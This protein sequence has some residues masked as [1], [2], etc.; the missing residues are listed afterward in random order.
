MVEEQVLKTEETQLESETKK[1]LPPAQY[2]LWTGK[3]EIIPIVVEDIIK[4]EFEIDEGIT[5]VKSGETSQIVISGFGLCLSKKSERMLVKKSKEILYEFPLFRISEVVIASKGISLSSDLI[6]ELCKRG[7]KISFL[8]SGGKPYAM[9]TSP[10]L[11]ATIQA[12]RCQLEALN[13][14]KSHEFSK[15]VVI[16]KVKNQ[17]RLLRYFGKYLKETDAPRFTLIE[18]ITAELQKIRKKVEQ[19]NGKNIEE[20]RGTLMGLEGSAG[21][22]YWEGVKE[23]LKHRVEFFGRETHGSIDPVNSL[24]NYGYGILYSIVWGAIVNAGLEP[25]AG[26]LHVDR[27][28]KPS[29]V[30]D[31]TEEFRQPVVDRVVIAYINL[32][33]DIKIEQ[34]LLDT[35]TRK[36]LGEKILER[37]ESKENYEGKKFQIRSI[38][39]IQARNLASFLRGERK[40]KPFTFKW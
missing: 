10:M 29:L 19:V 9:I 23:I 5:V 12:R 22:F 4:D 6:E 31:L 17:E 14:E 26:F 11:T 3:P 39:Q 37:L 34:G 21:R 15:A 28:G 36:L 30:L 18:S 38:I 20:S 35:E 13:N 7:I 16:G 27:P 1:S 40:Y 24:L 8:S 25:F 33:K 32:G 2:N